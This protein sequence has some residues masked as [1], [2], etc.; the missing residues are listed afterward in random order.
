MNNWSSLEHSRENSLTIKGEERLGGGRGFAQVW[1]TI[2]SLFAE[3]KWWRGSERIGWGSGQISCGRR[4]TS[5]A[6]MEDVNFHPGVGWGWG[7]LCGGR[8]AIQGPQN[9]A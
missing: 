7:V 9:E 4:K 8:V 6:V 3:L 2:G 5:K 1:Q